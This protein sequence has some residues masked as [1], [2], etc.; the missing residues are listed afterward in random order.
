[1]NTQH[2][3]AHFDS[4][5]FNIYNILLVNSGYPQDFYDHPAFTLFFLNSLVLKIYDFLD[6]NILFNIDTIHEKQ[7][8]D[9]YFEKIFYIARIINALVHCGCVFILN[10][11]LNKFSSDKFVNYLLILV[12]VCSN[13]FLENLFQIRP[14]IYSIF[15]FLLS[16]LLILKSLDGNYRFV[17]IF[18]SG[19]FIGLAYISKIQ[20][21]FFIFF[22]FFIFPYLSELIGRY[23]LRFEINFFENN[24][25]KYNYFLA[26]Y[27]LISLTY[28][29]IEYFIIYNH[30]RYLGHQKIDLY[31]FLLFNLFYFIYLKILSN[32]NKTILNLNILSSI[33]LFFGFITTVLFLISLNY[34]EIIRV[35]HNIYFKFLNP[36]YFLSNRTF[37]GSFFEILIL[38]FNPKILFE[39]IFF[40]F[41]IILL[42]PFANKIFKLRFFYLIISFGLLVLYIFSNNLRYFYL[43]E[44]YTFAV[45]AIIFALTKKKNLIKFRFLLIMTLLLLTNYNTFIKNNFVD[46]LQRTSMFKECKTDSWPL[47]KLYNGFDNWIPWTKKFSEKFYYKICLDTIKTIKTKENTR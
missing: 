31:G 36:Y 42:I 40:C 33:T 38:F 44:I 19:F 13:F 4:D 1:M 45:F 24:K 28:V 6:P 43:Y 29:G 20:I 16:F 14:E 37:D 15:F 2:W 26:F 21:I 23:N 39:N 41:S 8:L 25:K 3:S 7:N 10:L 12:L 11:I 17:L 5:W 30:P 9:I 34:L 35:N 27:F 46:Y 22:L 18:F 47:L 32:K